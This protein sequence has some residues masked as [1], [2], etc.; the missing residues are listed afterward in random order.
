MR[1]WKHAAEIDQ[2]DDVECVVDLCSYFE[3]ACQEDFFFMKLEGTDKFKMK[4]IWPTM[5]T[6][7]DITSMEWAAGPDTGR[8]EDH[9]IVQLLQVL[10]EKKNTFF[11]FQTWDK[12]TEYK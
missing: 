4:L 8:F 12:S 10:E 2:A 9:H 5:W 3:P 7:V 1:A 6:S 11:T